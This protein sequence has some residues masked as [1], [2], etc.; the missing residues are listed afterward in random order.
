[1]PAGQLCQGRQNNYNAHLQVTSD[2]HSTK[3]PGILISLTPVVF[4]V[5][6]LLYTVRWA[7]GPVQIPLLLATGFAALLALGLGHPWKQLEEGIL[8]GIFIALQACLVL[9]VIGT[10]IG[11]WIQA[12]IVPAMVY[13]G[14]KLL[15]PGWF[16]VMACIIC[17]II[18]LSTGSSWST[19]ATVGLALVGIGDALGVSSAMTAGAVISG[20]YFGDKMSPLSDTTN[21]SPA[22]AGS[23]IFDHIRHMIFTTGPSYV[24]ALIL[25]TVLG[26]QY[27][28]NALD[29]STVG[30]ML[31]TLEANFNI[32]V[33]L[34]LVPGAVIVMVLKRV[35]ALPAL[36]FGAIIGGVVARFAQPGVTL[37]AVL[38]A[39]YSGFVS[40]TGV[41][42]VD[43]LLTRGGMSSMMGTIALIF[44]ALAFGGV[45]ECS[46]ML[47]S[48]AGAILRLARGTGSLVTA[49]VVTC[50]GTNIIASDQYMSIV[51]PGRMY[52]EAFLKRGL[53]PKNL[54]RILEDAGTLTSPLIPWNTCGAFM[55]ATL[56]VS[57][58]AY[59]PFAFLNLANPLLSIFYGFT[60]LTMAPAEPDTDQASVGANL[61]GEGEAEAAS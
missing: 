30:T 54:S 57:A 61:Q 60:G 15:N 13:Y 9:M 2:L 25:Y 59:L 50:I 11:T 29:L 53:H 6:G 18:S 16:L 12:G 31:E 19:A 8:K 20:A 49:T 38:N 46:G 48:L 7:E 45:M 21:L 37:P 24:L 52:R 40:Q 17:S 36:F 34:L 4:L 42:A 56:G 47:G 33:W 3:P 39:S 23:E 1:M 10:L 26:W 35:P 22:V 55:G 28:D 43:S 44:C 14:L 32:T 27:R 51:I 58:A 5:L 41:E